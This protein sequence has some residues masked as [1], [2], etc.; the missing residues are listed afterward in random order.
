MARARSSGRK[1]ACRTARLGCQQRAADALEDRA[2]MSRPAVGA[3]PHR[4]DE[5]AN[6]TTPTEKIRLRP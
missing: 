3:M 6:Q 2:A 1:E 4:A 5:P